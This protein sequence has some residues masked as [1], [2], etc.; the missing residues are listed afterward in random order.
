[1]G[2]RRGA[3]FI[4]EERIA[5]HYMVTILKTSLNNL[6]KRGDKNFI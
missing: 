2:K 1:M 3:V 5:Q 4:V 6:Q